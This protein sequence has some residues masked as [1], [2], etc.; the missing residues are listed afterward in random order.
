M[1]K[2]RIEWT[3][4]ELS[5]AGTSMKVRSNDLIPPV[6]TSKASQLAETSLSDIYNHTFCKLAMDC[7]K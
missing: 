5:G 1:N 7:Q 6:P 4:R 3:Y 2:N